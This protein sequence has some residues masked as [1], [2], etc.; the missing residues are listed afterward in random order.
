VNG[1][2]DADFNTIDQT[3]S[4]DGTN[5]TEI[6]ATGPSARAFA[7][8]ATLNGTVVLFSGASMI[9]FDGPGTLADTATWTFD[10]TSWTRHNVPGPSARMNLLMVTE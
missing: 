1:G 4:F 6:S 2:E 9:G 10:G 8:M 3:W 5:W 7:G